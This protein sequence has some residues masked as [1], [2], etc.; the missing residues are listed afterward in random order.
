[1]L[2]G[3]K[4]GRTLVKKKK[5]S[6]VKSDTKNKNSDVKVHLKRETAKSVG[7]NILLMRWSLDWS[8]IR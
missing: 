8:L 3:L 6:T 7:A 2:P 1:V 4:S 5:K